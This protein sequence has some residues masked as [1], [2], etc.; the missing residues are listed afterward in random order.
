[1]LTD[2]TSYDE[3]RAVL[4]VTDEELEDDTLQLPLFE[5]KLHDDMGELDEGIDAAYLA[6]EAMAP[7]DLSNDQKKLYRRT[8]VW[9]TYNIAVQLLDSLALLAVQSEQ[10]A[11]AQYERFAGPFERVEQQVRATYERATQA[12]LEAYNGLAPTPAQARL[13]ARNF[14]G[15]A[16]LPL[17]PVTNQ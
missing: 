12:L 11:R 9:A 3:I 13:T 4:S 7:E 14:V 17:D 15:L 1:M 8:R 2:Y 5:Y 6:L 10:D 16:G